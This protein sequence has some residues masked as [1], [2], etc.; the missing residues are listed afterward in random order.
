MRP[1]LEKIAEKFYQK[2]GENVYLFRVLEKLSQVQLAEKS[3]VSA[4]YI[5]QIEGFRLHRGI[6]YT[7]IVNIAEALNIPPC[8][9][10]SQEPCPKYLECLQQVVI[11][12]DRVKK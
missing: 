10:F 5:N 9:L 6:T 4:A 8:V 11:R 12:P 2:I 1:K 7:A 3:Q